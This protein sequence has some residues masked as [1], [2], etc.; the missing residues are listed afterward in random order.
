MT[1]LEERIRSGLQQTAERISETLPDHADS[2]HRQ[3][4]P[5]G[6]WAGVAAVVAVLVIFTPILFLGGEV[7][8]RGATSPLDPAIDADLVPAE[9][10]FEFANPE[11]VR[12]RFTQDLRLTCEGLETVDNGGF[13]SF[14]VDIWIDHDAGYTRLGFDYPDGSEHDLI[15]KGRPDAWEGAWGQGADLGRSAGCRRPLDGGG[16]E[17]SI[18]GWAFQDSSELWFTAYLKPV[19]R[20]DEGVLINHEDHPTI[21]TPIGPN[22]YMIK[23]NSPDGTQLRFEFT[24]DEPEIRVVGEQRH[25]DVPGE[26]DANAT[27]ESIESGPA[28][29]PADIFDTS[30]FTPLWGNAPVVTTQSTTP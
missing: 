21:A 3:L 20:T 19:S 23:N 16:Y 5:V 12:L 17:Q 26:F 6:V 2:R 13:D 10:G 30:T 18:A 14:E 22:T 25:L 15:L 27:I 11:Y 9:V 8:E 7:G 4:R 28:A 24:L 29:L 1:Q